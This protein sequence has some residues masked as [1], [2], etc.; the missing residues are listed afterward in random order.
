MRSGWEWSC[1]IVAPSTMITAPGG[2][3]MTQAMVLQRG[4]KLVR[5][6]L[7][8]ITIR[9]AQ[10]AMYGIRAGYRHRTRNQFFDD[11]SHADDTW[12]REVY[13]TAAT[14]AAEMNAGTVV[15]FGCGSGFKLMKNFRNLATIGYEMPPTVDYLKRTYPDRDWR[16]GD[17]SQTLAPSDILICSDVIEHIPDPDELMALLQ[18]SRPKMLVLST[19]ERLL[20]YGGEHDGPPKNPAHCRE[21]AQAELRTYVSQW[22]DVVEWRIANRDQSTQMI[23]AK[24][25]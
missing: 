24:P 18:R 7:E 17:F 3:C 10:N 19:P 23:V 5:N 9:P 1:I 2:M 6:A 25:R 4:K 8:G 13:E 16:T 20:M 12:Q 14:L 15:D 22:F 11:T 21:W